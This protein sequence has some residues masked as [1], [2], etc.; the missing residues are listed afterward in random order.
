[1][2][3]TLTS[4]EPLDEL[5]ELEENRFHMKHST[6]ISFA[7]LSLAGG[8][9]LGCAPQTGTPSGTTKSSEPAVQ[10]SSEPA[11]MMQKSSAQSALPQ[12]EQEKIDNAMGAAPLAIAKDATVLDWPTK[13]GGDF[14]VLRKGANGWTCLPDFPVSPGN[15][16]MC[17]D[18]M[19]MQWAQAWMT[20]KE[21]KLAKAG[22]GYM[23]Q[24]GSDA[25]N[26]DPF[27]TK[28]AAGGDWMNAPPHVMIFTVGGKLDAKVYGT[29]PVNGGP[30]IMW[31]QT[32][33]QHLMVPV[34]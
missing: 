1:M 33:Y 8:L 6:L 17:M 20:K 22:L 25:S 14:P 26:T 13:E 30:W 32:P 4:I 31:S 18:A 7:S 27:A 34:K 3:A 16:P 21:P 19:A 11:A 2:D 24:G 15:D 9:L 29:D 12:T 23:L 10:S 5:N 28:P